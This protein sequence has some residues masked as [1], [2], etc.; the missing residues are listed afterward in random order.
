MPPACE[1]RRTRKHGRRGQRREHQPSRRQAGAARHPRRCAAPGHGLLHRHARSRHTGAAGRLRHLRT[2]RLGVHAAST[3]GTFSRSPRPSASSRRPRNRTARLFLGIDTHALSIPACATALEVLAANGVEVM[4]AGGRRIH[5]DP[6]DFARDPDPQS[7]AAGRARR[8]DRD[9]PLAQS[10]ARRRLQ[11]QPAR[12][13]GPRRPT[14]T[15]WIEAKANALL[16]G[17]LAGVRRIPHAAGAPRLRPPIGTTIS[18]AY[19]DDLGN[20]IDMDV[21]RG[22][23][24]SL[25][26]DPLGGA[27]VHYWARIADRHGLNLTV[28]EDA[29]RS[30]LPLHDRGL[31]RPDPDGSVLALC[32]GAADRDEG[33]LRPLVRLRHRPR[34]ARNRHPERR[35]ASAQSLPVRSPIST[36]FRA[37]RTVAKR[38]SAIGKTVV[39]SS[40]IDRVAA[41]LGRDAVRGAGRLQVV[42]GRTAR[43]FAGFGGEESAGA[44]FL[45]RDGS[46]WT[47]DKDGFIP[48]LLAAE[49]TA[50]TGR[51][52]GELY[53]DLT[54]EF[55][56]P[57]YDRVEAPATPAEKAA[58]AKLSARQVKAT[59]LAGEK[60]RADP[61]PRP[62]QRRADRGAEG[63][64][65]ERLVRRASFRHRGHLQDLRREF[66][67]GRPFAQ[68]LAE[69]QTILGAAPPRRK[70]PLR[71]RRPAPG[72][73]CGGKRDRGMGKRR[74]PELNYGPIPHRRPAVLRRPPRAGR[75]HRTGHGPALDLEP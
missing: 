53:R 5:A 43:R 12:T 44:T 51:D 65:R 56:E 49:I 27:G 35:A 31:G 22:A 62:G 20:V 38:Q 58:L 69:A 57:A 47:T 4:I 16:E 63:G 24:L 73:R 14:V 13:A 7:R 45:R 26:V 2:S 25:G 6:G 17:G 9:H 30:H 59:E 64:D 66:P 34:P 39:S 37:G 55:G 42:R 72:E 23:K 10:A 41:K 1:G 29:G 19:I 48:C 36:C 8:R 28:V 71:G 15:G 21:I 68:I 18:S 67:R 61:H 3:S 40:M 70:P 11:V 60:I 32:H 46:V 52:P 74:R 54:R 50:R 33:P 75:T